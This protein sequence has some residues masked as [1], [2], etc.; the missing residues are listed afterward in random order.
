MIDFSKL[1]SIAQSKPI[2][3]RDVFMGLPK[4]EKK[5]EY[6]RDVQTDVWKQWFKQRDN[7]ECIIKMN[8]GSGKTVVGLIILI[9]C[10]NE[11]KGPAVYIVPDNCLVQQVISEANALGINTTSDPDDIS[12]LR[13]QSVLISNIQTLI[14]GKSKFGM[15]RNNNIEI[16]SI[17]IDDVHSCLANIEQQFTITIPS[18]ES[19]Y[20]AILSLFKDD[21]L[22]Q[23]ENKYN[24]IVEYSDPY[25]SMLI[26]FWAW[27]AKA[28]DVYRLFAD[29]QGV[30]YVDF[31]FQLIKDTLPLCRCMVSSS[32]IEIS[33]KCIPIHK[34]G[35]FVRA[36]RK[37]Y[38]SATVADDSAFVTALDLNANSIKSIISPEKAND[39]GD[40]L[41]LFP[42]VINKRVTDEEIKTKLAS[43]SKDYNVVVITPSYK[44]ASYWSDVSNRILSATNIDEGIKELRNNHVGLVVLVNKYDGIDLPDDACRILVIDGLPRMRS[45]YDEYEHNANPGDRRLRREQIQKIEQGMG[46]G[47]RSNSD[48]CTIVLMG[49][50][51]ADI[52]YTSNGI[53]FFSNATKQQLKLSESIWEQV[54]NASIDEIFEI[55]SYSLHRN[56]S[57]VK[58]SK[59]LLSSVSYDTIPHF[60]SGVIAA[61]SAYNYAESG[62][63]KEAVSVLEQYKNSISDDKDTVGLYKMYISEY[64]NF[65]NPGEA[66]QI[67]LSAHA[68]NR[69]IIKPLA[70]IQFD[71]IINK[72]GAQAESF[73]KYTKELSLNPNDYILRINAI[74]DNLRFEE[75]TAK[76]FEQAMRDISFMIGLFST[77]PE[78]ETGRGPD[79]F[80]DLGNSK[81]AVIECKNGTITNTISKHDCNQMNG[82]INWFDSF[83]PS[84]DVQQFPVIVHNS[85]I[86]EYACSPNP[87]IRIMTPELLK[88]FK[89]NI[90]LFSENVVNPE[91]F[92]NAVNIN[93]L[94]SQFNLFGEQIIKEYTKGYRK[95]SV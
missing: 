67:L 71:R 65:Y 64:M 93:R 42:S 48:Y 33:P 1:S 61:R 55:S 24:N 17:I 5:Y 68:D 23:S 43:L 62:R 57:W 69:V 84:T 18:S 58:L 8:T 20:N 66:Q 89:A 37:I 32:N 9:S 72:T 90:H 29:M 91:N 3:P 92:Y 53:D 94:L 15:R 77:R 4:K 81:F 2:E 40:R 56:E 95:K 52:M 6:P 45:L 59:D 76:S 70:G 86:F 38:M 47:V 16:G 13:G 73:L 28:N 49:R 75:D 83:Y 60:E 12:F 82:S 88:S 39:I 46:R 25:E 74:L 79:N 85:D 51:L 19:C 27:Q 63:Y 21:L 44:R 7:R 31:N 87:Q 14:N 10:L 22:S 41:I 80:W 36:Q 35:S 30:S 50:A 26:P 78:E 11:N 34:I 54:K